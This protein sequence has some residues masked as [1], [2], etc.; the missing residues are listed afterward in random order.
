MNTLYENYD[1]IAHNLKVYPTIKIYPRGYELEGG[2]R[3]VYHASS[4]HIDIIDHFY[5]I[6]I[7]SHEMRHAYQYIYFPDLFFN[8]DYSTACEYLDCSIERDA[9]AYS[10]DYCLARQYWEEVEY[11]RE[12][13]RQ[14]ELV[15]QNKLSP[16]VR[17]LDDRYFRQNPSIASIVASSYHSDQNASTEMNISSN[18]GEEKS[19]IA[20]GCIGLLVIVSIVIIIIYQLN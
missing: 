4:N 14:I 13:E 8:T 17:G 20:L 12:D 2:F 7:I 3:G 5:L 6:S 18:S 19:Q 15:A 9:R 11:L 1:V 16:I 10:I